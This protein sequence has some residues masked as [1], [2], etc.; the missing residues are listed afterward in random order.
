MTHPS[1]QVENSPN[2]SQEKT[3][4]PLR[5]LKIRLAKG[6]ITKEEYEEMREII[7]S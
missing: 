1:S 5:I 2:V 6:E 3:D 7:E 4:E